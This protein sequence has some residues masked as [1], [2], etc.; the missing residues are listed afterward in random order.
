MKR[1]IIDVDDTISITHDGKYHEA[2][3][4]TEVVEKLRY[5]KNIGY[6]ITL[7]TSRNMRKFDGNIGKINT[8]TV[9]TLVE[10]LD[11]NKV[12]YDE[13][14]VGKPWCGREGFYVDDRAIRPDEFTSLSYEEIIDLLS[15]KKNTS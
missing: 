6:C 7:Y 12:P 1:I 5:Y 14:I 8:I 3:V 11:E 4:V 2:K 13:I 15:F 9:P 10:W